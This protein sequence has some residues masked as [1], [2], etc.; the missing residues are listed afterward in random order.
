METKNFHIGDVLS[1]T[2][3]L[4]VS[5][6]RMDG[7]YDILNWMTGESL[8][9]H[10]LPRVMKEAQPVLLKFHPQLADVV[11]PEFKSPD[12]VGAWVATQI[13][14]FGETLPVPKMSDDEHESIDPMSEAA[15]KFHPDKIIVVDPDKLS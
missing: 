13:N 8:F 2:T 4:L 1:I 3:G 14:A 15:E 12:D 9:T 5:P 6:R 7:I 10:Q 11:T